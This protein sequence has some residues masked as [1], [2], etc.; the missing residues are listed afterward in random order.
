M[1]STFDRVIHDKDAPIPGRRMG[2]PMKDA[3]K[4]MNDLRR[5]GHTLVIFT[6]WATT[7]AGKKSCEDWL[8]WW[9]VPFDYVTNIKEPWDLLIDDKAAKHINWPPSMALIEQR[10]YE[11]EKKL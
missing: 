7:P 8:K 4:A 5:A 1:Q 3:V 9:K 11:L 6:L 2:A 10:R